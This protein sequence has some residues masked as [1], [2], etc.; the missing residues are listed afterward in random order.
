MSR[1]GSPRDAPAHPQ[2]SEGP[3][4]RGG[5]Q[6]PANLFREEWPPP[7]G[8]GRDDGLFI[9]PGQGKFVGARGWTGAARV[10]GI[11]ETRR[12]GS[13]RR[14]WTPWE[15]EKGHPWACFQRTE[16]W[17]HRAAADRLHRRHP[18]HSGP[19]PGDGIGSI[20]VS[21][22][23]DVRA[24]EDDGRRRVRCPVRRLG[25]DP[26]ALT[27]PPALS[28]AGQA[29]PKDRA[30]NGRRGSRR[31]PLPAFSMPCRAPVKGDANDPRRPHS[32]QV[33]F[34]F[35]APGDRSRRPRRRMAARFTRARRAAAKPRGRH[36]PDV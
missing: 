2:R 36:H 26:R 32:A 14:T 24:V 18:R 12:D 20:R 4:R 1:P 9:R 8:A 6:G 33:S 16:D 27:G 22:S 7:I 25:T 5:P 31:L 10:H 13:A 21:A 29:G 35:L 34:V 15:T 19:V 17:L 28:V 30:I 3:D 11:Q 23:A